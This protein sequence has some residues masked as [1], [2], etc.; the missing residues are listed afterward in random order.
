MGLRGPLDRGGG[1]LGF[2]L[3]GLGRRGGFLPAGEDQSALGDPY[4]VRKLAVALGGAGLP[5]QRTGAQFHVGEHFVEPDEVGLR[6]P[7]FLFG[8]LSAHVEAGDAGGFLQHQPTLGRLGRDDG[9]DLALAHQSR[10]MGAG[11]GVGEQQGYVLGPDVAAVDPVGGA[12]PAFD[13]AGDLDLAGRHPAGF[14]GDVPAL[15]FEKE[16]DLGEIAGR[17]HRGSGEDDVVHLAAAHRLGRRFAHHPSDR[18][19]DV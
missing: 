13:P 2:G 19:E 17:A 1:G 9:A 16:R 3:G 11:G 15:A 8:V 18:L 6:R 4:L 10:R 12:G 5:L 7:Q 14:G